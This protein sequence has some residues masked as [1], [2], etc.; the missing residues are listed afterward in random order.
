MN[1]QPPG[2]GC[3]P[4][5]NVPP[6]PPNE[7]SLIAEN[8]RR[9]YLKVRQTADN[10]HTAAQNDN[11]E[12]AFSYQF[13]NNDT[14]V[15]NIVIG[16]DRSS[17]PLTGQSIFGLH[18][19]HQDNGL[20]PANLASD[21]NQCFDTDD[22]FKFYTD[23]IIVAGSRQLRM[24]TITTRDY[25]YAAYITNVD[26]FKARVV[27]KAGTTVLAMMADNL[28]NQFDSLMQACTSPPACTYE[29]KSEQAIL[30]IFGGNNSG[31]KFFKSPRNNIN[32]T[33]L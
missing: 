20:P 11:N 12:R 2:T 7:D 5:W 23:Q 22:I 8:L 25:V 4:G 17:K 32:F 31:I 24:Q 9:A 16:N 10:L 19:T 26:A 3:P 30:N 29:R 1:A 15:Y 6:P 14:V 13:I 18:H 28:Y 33:R 21:A 27:S